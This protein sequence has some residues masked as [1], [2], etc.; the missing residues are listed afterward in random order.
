MGLDFVAI[1]F[2]TANPNRASVI[3]I[4][5]VRVLNGVPGKMHSRFVTP[6]PGHGHFDGFLMGIHGLRP[7]HIIGAPGWPEILDI[8]DRFT[9]MDYSDGVQRR[10][11]LVA[12]YASVER[13]VIEQA[14]SAHG[15]IPPP[16][17]YFC[18]VKLAKLAYPNEKTYSL[19]RLYESIG[20][21][22]FDH[23]DA[24]ADA[25]ASADLALTIF[26]TKGIDSLADFGG[27]WQLPPRR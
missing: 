22:A 1:D 10:L 12:H 11:P 21:P 19:G 20:L 18:T 14:S 3:Q 27:K 9:L 15:L 16:F 24:G 13:S 17:D 5:I 23:H 25:K 2:E 6:P 26:G 7:A 4:G 8:L